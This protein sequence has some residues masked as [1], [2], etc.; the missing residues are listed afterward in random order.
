MF[1]E[2]AHSADRPPHH[3]ETASVTKSD[4]ESKTLSALQRQTSGHRRTLVVF[5]KRANRS[6]SLR[7]GPCHGSFCC[8]A[9]QLCE[10][11]RHSGPA[12]MRSSGGVRGERASDVPEAGHVQP[13]GCLSRGFRFRLGVQ[14][15]AAFCFWRGGGGFP[16]GF[17]LYF[18]GR[19]GVRFGFGFGFGFKFG[20]HFVVV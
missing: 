18:S 2:P 20:L 6:R 5:R 7:Q 9:E 14:V 4:I 10:I 12:A 1:A 17:G 8:W 16:F 3:P 11:H 19:G 15:W 13:Q